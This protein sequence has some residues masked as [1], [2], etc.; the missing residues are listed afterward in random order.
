MRAIAAA[1]GVCALSGK[2]VTCGDA[3]FRPRRPLNSGGNALA[4]ILA[5]EIDEAKKAMLADERV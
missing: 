3:V 1:V 4:M 5:T 2:P